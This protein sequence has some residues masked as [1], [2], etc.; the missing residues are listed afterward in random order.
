ML[1][2]FAVLVGC[3]PAVLPPSRPAPALPGAGTTPAVDDAPNSFAPRRPGRRVAGLEAIDDLRT[4]TLG[5]ARLAVHFID[6]GQGDALLIETPSNRRIL[7]DSGPSKSRKRLVAYLRSA[8]VDRIDVVVNSHGHADHIGGLEQVIKSMPIRYVLD[9]GFVH[10]TKAF[11]RLVSRIEKDR[12]PFKLAGVTGTRTLSVGPGRPQLS[13]GDGPPIVKTVIDE[14]DGVTLDVLWPDPAAYVTG[15]RSDPNSNSVVLRVRYKNV[16][17]LLTGDAEE[18]T[19]EKL[20]EH[21]EHLRA[22]V[23]KVAHHGSRHASTPRFLN[24]VR[25]RL[26]VISCGARN[27]YGHPAPE[28]IA[29]LEAAGAAV[30]STHTLGHV[31]VETDGEKLRVSHQPRGQAANT[32]APTPLA[33]R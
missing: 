31:I 11:E 29:R 22:T 13:A 15:S 26:A 12:I 25:P 10:P 30:A 18:I 19:E 14:A 6:I 24:A 21:P 4:D 9:S 7:V 5:D 28:A 8:G 32:S 17:F 16:Q 2:M 33:A 3:G 23:L 20:L 27:R 1:W